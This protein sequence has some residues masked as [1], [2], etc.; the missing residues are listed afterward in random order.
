MKVWIKYLI[1]I[2]LGFA[3]FFILPL[4]ENVLSTLSEFAVH[5]GRYAL[6]PLVFFGTALA[7][8]RLRTNRTLLKTSIWTF[9]MIF[10]FTFVLTSIGIVSALLIKLPRIPITG[11][12][13][14]EQ[15]PIDIKSLVLQLV[16]FSAFDSLREGIYILPIFVFAAFFGAGCSSEKEGVRVVVAFV[17]SAARIMHN[18]AAF[19]AEWISV[20]LIAVTCWWLLCARGGLSSPVFSKMFLLLLVD[21]LIFA[22]VLCPLIIR[23]VCKDPRPFHVLYASV[24]PVLAAFFSADSNFSLLVNM[25]HGRESLGIRDEVNS[26]SF[27]LCSAFSRGGASLVVSVC[28]VSIVR[29]YVDLGIRAEDVFWLFTT[30][31][32][33]SFS[34]CAL[35]QGGA[36]VA[37]TIICTMYGRGFADGFLLL[38]P[39]L[40]FLC[41]FAAIFDATSAIYATYIVAVKT[42]A[43]DHNA[44]KKYI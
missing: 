7:V 5:F 39:A 20:G 22:G 41:S 35:P 25:R 43:I 8:F 15:Q 16:P 29:S 14:I 4:G 11:E 3:A 24:A 6:F 9:A 28:F 23:L 44:I 31:A 38:R 30:A 2:A 13:M 18:I 37:L 10:L 40:P 21:F 34:L 33:V 17:E 42:K 26:F 27:P 1:G 36:S 12:R 19:F 32:A